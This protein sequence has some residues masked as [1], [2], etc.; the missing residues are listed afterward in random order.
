MTESTGPNPGACR[1][2]GT[3]CDAS[4]V[5]CNLRGLGCVRGQCWK[6]SACSY[7]EKQTVNID[8][9]D[10]GNYAGATHWVRTRK[11]WDANYAMYASYRGCG[12]LC[13]GIQTSTTHTLVCGQATGSCLGL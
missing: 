10:D 2:H 1:P 9:L 8:C 13:P 11:G 4:H 12:V 6:Q 5:C 3:S 7:V